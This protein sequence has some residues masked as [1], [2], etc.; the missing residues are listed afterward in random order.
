MG[1]LE[2]SYL[3]LLTHALQTLQAPFPSVKIK[4]TLLEEKCAFSAVSGLPLE[5]FS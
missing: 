2:N 3:A 4:G 1:F 5:Q